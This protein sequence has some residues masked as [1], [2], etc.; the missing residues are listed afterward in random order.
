MQ[1][2]SLYSTYAR[3]C[4]TAFQLESWKCEGAKGNGLKQVLYQVWHYYTY[5]TKHDDHDRYFIEIKAFY[6]SNIIL[7]A[8]LVLGSTSTRVFE[9]NS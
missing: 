6:H 8:I 4:V 7:Y 1:R 2:A 5:C 9:K 3:E